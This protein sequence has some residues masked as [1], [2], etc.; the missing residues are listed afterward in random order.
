MADSRYQQLADRTKQETEATAGKFAFQGFGRSTDLASSVDEVAKKGQQME[1]TLTNIISL[2]EMLKKATGKEAE[3]IGKMLAGEQA[4]LNKQKQEQDKRL[5][6]VAQ[7]ILSAS[8]AIGDKMKYN[9]ANRQ[10][11]RGKKLKISA[12]PA[13][14][15][16][17]IK[18]SPLRVK[19][20]SEMSKSTLKVRPISAI[21][22]S[23]RIKSLSGK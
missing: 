18:Q 8:T 23:Q 12:A 4:N 22:S 7:S 11:F 5:S 15:A 16:K 21:V 13:F 19:A 17:A 3:G 14:K 10:T 6:E 20:L 2:E 9:N 1:A